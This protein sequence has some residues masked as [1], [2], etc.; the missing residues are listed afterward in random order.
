MINKPGTLTMLVRSVLHQILHLLTNV[1]LLKQ[2]ERCF[3]Y[4]SFAS[5]IVEELLFENRKGAGHSAGIP[6]I[7]YISSLCIC[8]R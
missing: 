7:L 2:I 6:F 3:V 5:N 1:P 8:D 4:I